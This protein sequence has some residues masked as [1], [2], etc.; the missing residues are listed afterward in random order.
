M[1]AGWAVRIY[2]AHV[3]KYFLDNSLGSK[4]ASYK[5]AKTFRD[6]TILD[7]KHRGIAIGKKP[8]EHHAR[9]TI[10]SKTGIVGVYMRSRVLQNGHISRSY[11][12]SYYPIKYNHA[13]KSFSVDKYGKQ[14]ALQMAIDFREDGLRKSKKSRG[15]R[16]KSSKK[17]RK[18]NL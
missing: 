4:K 6:E 9:P 10:K 2:F 7:L 12:G 14:E 13:V 15:T 17:A 16:E 1:G 8:K 3:I 18:T 5:A 11:F